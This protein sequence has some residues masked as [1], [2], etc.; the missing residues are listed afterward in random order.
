MRAPRLATAVAT[1]AALLGAATACGSG[2]D[3][4]NL[5]KAVAITAPAAGDLGS[6]ADLLKLLG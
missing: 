4:A 1:A 5:G 2:G 3:G 6:E